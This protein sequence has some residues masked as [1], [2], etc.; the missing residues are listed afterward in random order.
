MSWP[1]MV[2]NAMD[3]PL[4]NPMQKEISENIFLHE[5]KINCNKKCLNTLR[6][7]ASQVNSSGIKLN[8]RQ[9]IM[10]SDRDRVTT[11]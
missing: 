2:H 7:T 10:G 11:Y 9:H 8:S 1:K 6:I 5:I 3:P 4:I